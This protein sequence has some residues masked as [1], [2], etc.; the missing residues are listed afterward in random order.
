MRRIELA[1]VALALAAGISACGGSKGSSH[2]IHSPAPEA[3]SS[4]A[5]A[6]PAATSETWASVCQQ[7]PN[8]VQGEDSNGNQ[9]QIS[10]C[11]YTTG[12][13]G[14]G[15]QAPIGDVFVNTVF[16]VEDKSQATVDPTAPFSN[17]TGWFVGTAVNCGNGNENSSYC[18]YL[19]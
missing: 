1:L 14:V 12:Y 19:G 16:E 18:P 4:G 6:S 7:A 2:A 8:W 13:D 15:G 3:T 17:D 10:Y 9:L 11:G 5:P